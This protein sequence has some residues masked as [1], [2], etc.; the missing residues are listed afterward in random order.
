MTT[1]DTLVKKGC[2]MVQD[3][4][5][6]YNLIKSPLYGVV[7]GSR[8]GSDHVSFDIHNKKTPSDWM[9]IEIHDTYMEISKYG[10]MGSEYYENIST[11]TKQ[12][13]ETVKRFKKILTA[14]YAIAVIKQHSNTR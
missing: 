2:T 1:H 6:I 3:T 14:K 9:H 5:D 13:L 10:N 4:N 11:T 12:G 8:N 7:R